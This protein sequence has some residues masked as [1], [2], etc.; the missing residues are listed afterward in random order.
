MIALAIA[1]ERLLRAALLFG[2]CVVLF[3]VL[4][5]WRPSKPMQTKLRPGLGMDCAFWFVT[6]AIS[7]VLSISAIAA[8]VVPCYLLLGRPLTWESIS[9]GFGPLAALPLWAQGLLAIAIGDFIGYW[10]H[11]ALFHSAKLWDFHAIHHSSETLDWLSANRIHP[12]NDVGSRVC[13]ALPILLLG[14][15]PIAVEMYVPF[16]TVYVALIHA[17]VNWD[18]GPLKYWIASPAFHRWHHTRDRDGL[19]KNFAGLFPIFDIL[20]GTFYLPPRKRPDN[21]GLD[22]EPL[23][24]D[25]ARQLLYPFRRKRQ[26]DRLPNKTDARSSV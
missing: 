20:F 17:N 4:E 23:E 14:L 22:G 2:I 1:Q 21:F 15:S 16:L 11:R 24:L 26:R 6:P 3:F 13:Q 8:V 25:F 12:L 18:Y 5:S 9:H 7:Q 10:T 19:D